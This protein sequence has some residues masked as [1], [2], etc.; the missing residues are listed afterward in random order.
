MCLVLKTLETDLYSPTSYEVIKAQ[1][2][3]RNSRVIEFILYDQGEPY[4]IP[5]HTSFSLTGHRGDGSTFYKTG[6]DCITQEDNHIKVT[7]PEDV[8]YH[9]GIIEAKL[10]LCN[11]ISKTV[12]STVPF[13][14]SCIKSP[15]DESAL[16]GKER[17][18]ISD[19]ILK[20]NSLAVELT[21]AE[22]D[23]LTPAEQTNGTIYYISDAEN[24]IPE[25]S[26]T[27]AGLMSASDKA[28]LNGIAE[29]ANTY[30]L[31]LASAGTRGGVKTGYVQNDK[32]YPVQLSDDKMFVNVP[33]ADT[34]TIT[35]VKGN[36]ETSYRTGNVNITPADIGLE[37]INNT[38]D[39]NK[40]VLSATQ[41]TTS[42]NIDGIS[43]NGSASITHYSTC[44]TSASTAAKTV[45]ISNF[46]L[47]TGAK[48]SVLFSYINTAA[49]PTLNV[50]GTGAKSIY[51]N[52]AALNSSNAKIL[53]GC[54]E[55]VYSGSYWRLVGSHTMVKGNAESAYRRDLV[56]ITPENIGTV[57]IQKLTQAQ[58]D[59]LSES[60]KKNG[61]IYFITD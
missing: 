53:G 13:K 49:N 23:A 30:S 8:L 43:F 39:S 19:L 15:L 59:A 32:N 7:L 16:S 50:S 25:A 24:S 20:A 33:W 17:S 12:L 48:I 37:N 42:R 4:K 14:I 40:N 52:N 55:F 38:S 56:N 34:Q 35:G 3:D 61:T 45:S 36:A 5:D 44:S 18:V 27:Q 2:G 29:N 58:Y 46:S 31:P 60:T 47:A 22:Y 51:Y 10:V 9:A 26:T 11:D 57:P 6:N 41:L 21:Q 1:Q 54:C 28:K